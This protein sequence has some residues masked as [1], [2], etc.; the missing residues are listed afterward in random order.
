MNTKESKTKNT[1]EQ[2]NCDTQNQDLKDSLQPHL[3]P[4]KHTDFS[5]QLESSGYAFECLKCNSFA[6]FNASYEQSLLDDSE[7]YEI[8]VK[9]TYC[10]TAELTTVPCNNDFLYDF[11][12]KYLELI[13]FKGT[14]KDSVTRKEGDKPVTNRVSDEDYLNYEPPF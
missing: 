8:Y 9:C 3:E 13:K 5:R 6:K 14:F 1:S 11:D 7:W 2:E 4:L 10:K 12:F